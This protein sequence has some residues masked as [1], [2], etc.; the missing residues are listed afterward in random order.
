M[1]DL[2]PAIDTAFTGNATLA[3][4][5]PGSGAGNRGIRYGFAPRTVP[6]PYVVVIPVSAP[7]TQVYGGAGYA[8]HRIQFKVVG[9]GVGAARVLARTFIAQW[10][11]ITL[12]VSGVSGATTTKFYGRRLGD[13]MPSPTGPLGEDETGDDV[14]G[15]DVEY[16]YGIA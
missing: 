6:R 2:F 3:A 15:W 16:V 12:A 1:I 10:D 8:E 14:A 11:T 13:P 9:D 5:F 7:R 4:A